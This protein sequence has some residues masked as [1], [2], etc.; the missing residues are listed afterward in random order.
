MERLDIIA[1]MAA[2]HSFRAYRIFS[3]NNQTVARLTPMTIDDLSPGSVVLKVAFSSVNYKDALAGTGAGKVV[4][5]F[6][7][8]GGVDLSGTV[9]SSEDARFQPGDEVIATSYDLGVSHDG[10]FADF[11]RVPAEWIV[12]LPQG[13]SLH[14]AMAIGTAGLTA[15]LSIVEMERNGLT[16]ESGPVVVTG[17]TGGVGCMAVQALAA[18]G[19]TVTALTGKADASGFLHAIGAATVL[20]RADLQMGTRPLQKATWAGAVDVAGGDILAWLTRT[21][22][23]GGTIASSGLTAGH[24]LHTT[25]MPFILRG[26]K[27]LGIDSAACAMPLRREVWSRLA[28]DLRPQHLGQT[29]TTITLDDLPQTF[30]ALLGGRARGRYMVR[31]A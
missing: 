23:Q 31:L 6:P 20:Q 24:E 25:V 29:T 10:G 9:V 27:L 8:V 28:G 22:T 13:L 11:A 12:P 19:Y 1:I 14:D 5:R 26:V 18:R 21:M 16:P 3:E 7:V 30:D 15:G 17:A 4:R 2:P